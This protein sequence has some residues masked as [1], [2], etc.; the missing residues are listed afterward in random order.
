LIQRVRPW[1]ATAF[2]L[3]AVWIVVAQSTGIE[4]ATLLILLGIWSAALAALFGIVPEQRRLSA[5]RQ[6]VVLVPFSLLAGWTTAA[7]FL[8]VAG[9]LDNVFG[10]PGPEFVAIAGATLTGITL[11]VKT[12]ANLWFT[13]TLAYAFTG[14]VLRTVFERRPE[15]TTA[16]AVGLG[17]VVLVYIAARLRVSRSRMEGGT[18]FRSPSDK[19]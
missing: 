16:A 8:S 10:T 12:R 7:T 15:L 19:L 4:I 17:V 1:A 13:L 3:N 6:A 2:F 9:L 11:I 14:I 5:L 18:S